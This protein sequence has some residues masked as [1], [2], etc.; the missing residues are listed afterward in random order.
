MQKI[1]RI[2]LGNCGYKT[3]WYDGVMLD[4]RDLDFHAPTD[5]VIN[6]E[7]GGGKT[8][9][10]SLIFS[11]FETSQDRFLKHIQSR[12][13]HFSQYFANDGTLGLIL[14]EWR[15]PPRNMLEGSY[16]LI[17]GQAVA[18]RNTTEPAEIER[19]FFS[20]EED[21]NLSLEQV[22]G[23][24]LCD[25]P[26]LA[27]TEFS[28]WLH[29][30]MRTSPSVYITR[31]QSDWHR[32]LEACLI[33]IEMLRMQVDFS[34]QEGGFDAGF[35]NFKSEAEF[36]RKFFGLTL[37]AQRASSVREA[38]ATAC[39]KLRR[40]PQF[41]RR[42]VQLQNFSGALSTFATAAQALK[43][44]KVQHIGLTWKGLRL[45]EALEERAATLEQEATTESTWAATQ[46][47][48][49]ATEE[50]SAKSF[51]QEHE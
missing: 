17:T 39:D 50:S 3:A 13:N 4:L 51:T 12:N 46:I 35:L 11:C 1:S 37:D 42:L 47:A 24:K 27:L 6:L 15:M 10:L 33:D 16:H 29:D 19:L 18:V 28:R 40:K 8:S 38:V 43:Q 49:A 44:E 36:L 20:F 25:T 48:I 34:A 7:N 5:T 31:K 21:G 30:Q 23:P 9:L 45:A 32:H 41:Q 14:V 26:L 22:P 2:Y